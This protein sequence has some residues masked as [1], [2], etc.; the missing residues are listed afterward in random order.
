MMVFRRTVLGKFKTFPGKYEEVLFETKLQVLVLKIFLKN[1]LIQMSSRKFS[2]IS[3]LTIF[4]DTSL[5]L[6]L[7]SGF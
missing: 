6:L 1:T 3:T 2:K 5:E 7:V 4:Q